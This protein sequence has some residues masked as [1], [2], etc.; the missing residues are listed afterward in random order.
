MVDLDLFCR[1][2]YQQPRSASRSHLPIVN[3]HIVGMPDFNIHELP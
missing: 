1:K 2:T 3:R